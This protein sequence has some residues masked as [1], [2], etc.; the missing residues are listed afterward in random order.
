MRHF[1]VLVLR[2]TLVFLN[3]GVKRFADARPSAVS[4]LFSKPVTQDSVN[5]HTLMI[6]SISK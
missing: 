4:R 6:D 1:R 3:D 5:K 2:I